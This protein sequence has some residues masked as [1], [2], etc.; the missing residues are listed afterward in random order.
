VAREPVVSKQIA[1][2]KE[3]GGPKKGYLIF[4]IFSIGKE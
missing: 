1:V 2:R 4:I 3:T